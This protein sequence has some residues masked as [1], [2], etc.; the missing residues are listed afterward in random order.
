MQ[1]KRITE[2]VE[3]YVNGTLETFES[4]EKQIDIPAESIQKKDYEKALGQLE[5]VR[6]KMKIFRLLS[7]QELLAILMRLGYAQFG[8]HLEYISSE[9]ESHIK[10]P[11]GDK[12]KYT[13]KKRKPVC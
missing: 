8:P 5:V 7:S 13:N 6:D 1:E 10:A 4:L 3:S 2:Q 11:T 12:Q 9:L